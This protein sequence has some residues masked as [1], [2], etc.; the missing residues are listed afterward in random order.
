[1][2][3]CYS[4]DD[5]ELKIGT[6]L[7][8]QTQENCFA[9]GGYKWRT[10]TAFPFVINPAFETCGEFTLCDGTKVPSTAIDG[11]ACGPGNIE[12]RCFAGDGGPSWRDSGIACDPGAVGA[13]ATSCGAMTLCGGERVMK[14]KI[15]AK[16]CGDKN[17]TYVCGPDGN[18]VVGGT[19]GDETCDCM[20]I[21]P[22]IPGCD[23]NMAKQKIG[24]QIC[25]VDRK[26]RICEK[27]MI[28]V[29][30]W[31]Y[32]KK[33]ACP[34]DAPEPL[35]VAPTPAPTP[36]PNSQAGGASAHAP[37]T[38]G[39]NTTIIVGVFVL[40]FMMIMIVVLVFVMRGKRGR[41]EFEGAAM[42]LRE[43]LFV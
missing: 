14:S 23:G 30:S 33:C 22:D 39:S 2:G 12:F 6:T 9:K 24:A 26:T 31:T 21:C 25:G 36:T 37:Q 29:P 7:N 18:W 34:G 35:P 20:T 17:L 11:K 4:K 1:M 5:T 16:E 27:N 43:E 19:K 28:G 38:G 3:T 40:L 32:G 15:G 41:G 13:C 8:D 10:N 42:P